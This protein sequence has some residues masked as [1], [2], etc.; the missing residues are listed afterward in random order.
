MKKSLPQE[1]GG[2]PLQTVRLVFDR[3]IYTTVILEAVG[4]ASRF[5]WIGTSD[6]KDLYV[7]KNRRMAPFLEMLSDLAQ[8]GVE[9]RLI[10]AKEPGPAFRRDFDKYPAL[11]NGLERIL[12]PR[13]HFKCVIVDGEFAY[14][15]S[16][17]LTGAGMG[18]KGSARRN[19]ETGV[20]T[21]D[22]T[23]IGQ[24]MEQFDGVWMG[25]HCAACGR[26]SYCAD[27]RDLL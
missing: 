18:A 26:K 16:A 4:A 2:K 27:Y 5:L 1:R 13:V 19:F 6:M 15:G 17:N 23:L 21:T 11:V 10:H 20:V 25:K 3:D 12:C 9:L 24:I 22:K 14:T 8:R 7:E